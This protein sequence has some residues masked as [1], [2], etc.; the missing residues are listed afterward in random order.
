MGQEPEGFP[1]Q[2]ADGL[3]LGC[4]LFHCHNFEC[5][6]YAEG[7]AFEPDPN[8]YPLPLLLQWLIEQQKSD[9]LLS[10]EKRARREE[11]HR[12]HRS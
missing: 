10:G 7:T 11:A 3:S 8:A 12:S 5:V 9:G 6:V 4:I 2:I 1:P